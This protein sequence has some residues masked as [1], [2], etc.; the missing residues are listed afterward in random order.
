MGENETF[1]KHIKSRI[2][3]L[4]LERYVAYITTEL[5]NEQLGDQMKA[6]KCA[7]ERE[8]SEN[9]AIILMIM[10]FLLFLGK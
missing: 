1:A 3:T 2:H 4:S 7:R 8:R 6:E 10:D 9:R 5:I